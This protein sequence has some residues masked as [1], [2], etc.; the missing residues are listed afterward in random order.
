MNPQLAS[1]RAAWG[2]ARALGR[3]LVMPR[4]TC[5]MDRV[6]FPHDGVFPGSDPLFKIPFSPCP[7]DHILDTEAMDRNGLLAG[8]REW[9]LLDNDKL[10]ARVKTSVAV[11]DW[12]PADPNVAKDTPLVDAS[13]VQL[14]PRGITAEDAAT[15][16]APLADRRH[17]HFK[18][19]P[20]G[21]EAFGGF[22]DAAKARE[23][24]EQIRQ[25]PAMWCCINEAQAKARGQPFPPGQ[26]WYDL[27]W[28]IV[29]H[30]DRF[31]RRWD[32]PWTIKLG[33]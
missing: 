21:K 28:D 10:P 3:T 31:N 11:L 22:E 23:F 8:V 20:P 15:L 17:L 1:L 14:L 5:G 27:Q 26:T 19:M 4:F 2:L 24:E 6:W 25:A 33:P 16:L 30:T 29:P 12:L 18:S 9:S 13:G 7:M 32:G